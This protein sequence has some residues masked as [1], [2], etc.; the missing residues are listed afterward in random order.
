MRTWLNG[1]FLLLLA[2]GL[3]LAAAGTFADDE[4][5]AT[6]SVGTAQ[7]LERQVAAPHTYNPISQVKAAAPRYTLDQV[8][9]AIN[10]N[11]RAAMARVRHIP[12]N[13]EAWYARW[14]MVSEAKQT[15]D[16]TY[17][18]LD[19]DIFGQAY[20]GLLMRKARE[21]VKIR[22]MIDGR[23]YR[24][25]Y[26]KGMPDRIQELAA[27]PGVQI[28]LYNSISHSLLHAI[29]DVKGLFASNHDK[30]I[31]VDGKL[32]IIGGRNIGPDYFAGKGEYPIVYRDADI[33]MEGPRIAA[34]LKAAFEFEWNSK[35]NSVVKPDRWNLNQQR[36]RLEI[37]AQVMERYIKGRGL[38]DPSRTNLTDRQKEILTELNGEISK[39][40]NISKYS[41]YVM[42]GRETPLPVKIIDK[43]SSF[44]NMD[45]IT[46]SLVA[47]F[48]AAREEIIIQ[49]PYVVL[50][51]EAWQALRRA[52]A[53]KVKIIFHSNSGASTDSLFPQAFLMNDWKQMLAE[54]PTCRLYV[55]PS[56]N[57]RLHSKTFVI[58]SKITII[59]SYNM[60][61]L[62]Q[63]SNSEVV[64]A[65]NDERFARETRD[66]IMKDMEVVL[67]YKIRIEPDGTITKVF[68][69]EDHLDPKILK[70]MN[71]YRKLKWIR[72]VI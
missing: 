47:F 32:S 66:Q 53:R 64:A 46:P 8:F 11:E 51:Q 57:E 58:D 26:M 50:T 36:D 27:F 9:A 42:W 43:Y 1:L 69:P 4:V 22:L 38:F 30:I 24:S 72:P 67:E 6:P 40:K 20:L 55:A 15:I 54:M 59:G 71:F 5:A 60:D 45:G 41:S 70:R 52:S 34:S 13:D 3:A 12:F 33:L 19:K 18:I 25:P 14:K 62:S 56:Q 23:I 2:P 29:T 17:Y 65:V 61:P 44:G 39:F 63:E 7:A 35:R 16:C 10:K 21:G 37:A 31:I 49:N 68:G 48:D 28:K